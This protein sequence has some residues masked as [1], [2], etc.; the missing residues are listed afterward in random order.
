MGGR[1]RETSK[2]TGGSSREGEKSRGSR[3]SCAGMPDS[4]QGTVSNKFDF[5]SREHTVGPGHSEKS[6]I[7]HQIV[8]WRC[9]DAFACCECECVCVCVHK[10]EIWCR[11]RLRPGT[12]WLAG[13]VVFP[14][15]SPRICPSLVRFT[16]SPLLCPLLVR[17]VNVCR[18]HYCILPVFA[19]SFPVELSG[20][21]PCS[22]SRDHQL[23]TPAITAPR[24]L[25]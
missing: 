21:Q 25:V 16:A 2:G 14:A 1:E 20:R 18:P 4:S 3:A 7:L 5:M 15:S 17:S 8:L 10:S 13:V 24:R 6:L 12:G 9:I 19:G 22:P 11:R 23:D